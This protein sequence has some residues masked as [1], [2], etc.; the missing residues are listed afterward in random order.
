MN[1]LTLAKCVSG[2]AI[3]ALAGCGCGGCFGPVT[4]LDPVAQLDKDMV[5]IPGRDYAICKYEVTQA[6]WEAVMGENPSY[7]K[8]ANRPVDQVSWYDCQKFLEKLNALPKVRESG[9]TYR[10]P[11]ADEWEYACLAGSTYGYCKLADGTEIMAET[12]GDV[13][14]YEDN[15][16]G[17]T[18]PVGQKKPN[19]YGLYDML[20][21]VQEWTSTIDGDYR[22]FCGGSWCYGL[23]DCYVGNRRMASPGYRYDPL[24]FRLAR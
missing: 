7:F 11:T 18:H 19:A 3:A 9:M 16:H 2:L 13:A 24:G 4:Q 12:L 1:I 6:L 10:F 14:W 17:K 22:V 5:S 8:G 21:N 15:S 23:P 20:G